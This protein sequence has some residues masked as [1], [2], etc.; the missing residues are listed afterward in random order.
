MNAV[1][2]SRAPAFVRH[3][4]LIDWVDQMV[5]LAKP[6]QVVWCDGSAEENE[7]L[8]AQM[9]ASGMLKKLNPTK[10]HLWE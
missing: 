7:R 1:L 9:V 6:D 4:K 5:A 8:L 2:K 10:P 3:A